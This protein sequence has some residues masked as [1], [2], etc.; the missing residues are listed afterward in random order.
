M[1]NT[2]FKYETFKKDFFS[3]IIVF[4]IAI[5]LCIGIA[6]ACGLSPVSGLI[7]GI[8][9]GIIIGSLSGCPLQV[10]GPAAGLITLVI[11]VVQKYGIEAFGVIVLLAGLIQILVGVFKLA[12]W[13]RA[14]SPAII[15]GMLTGIG[16]MILLSQFHVMLD[17]IPSREPLIN[18]LSIPDAI[19]KGVFPIDGSS[20]HLAAGVGILTISIL[21]LWHYIPQKFKTIPSALVAVLASIIVSTIFNLPIKYISIPSNILD[22]LNILSID[23]LAS[24][25]LNINIIISAITFA[26]IA[27]AETLLSANA[28]DKMAQNSKTNYNKE[29]F[30]QGLGNSIA[31]I[32]GALPITGVIVRSSANIQAGAETRVSTILHGFWIL[33]LVTLCPFILKYIP[34]ACL[35]ALLVYTGYKLVNIQRA[36]EI[37][38]ISK[39]EFIIFLIT[40]LAIL[41]T[42][43]LEGIL[44]G[45]GVSILKNIYRLTL[46]R[47]NIIKNQDEE[48]FVVK[49]TG[50][51]T[52][53]RLPQIA[54]IIENMEPKKNINIIFEHTTVV[55]HSIIDLLIGWSTR[56]T[57][58]GGNVLID[59][60]HLKR[61]YP[62]FG[63]DNCNNIAQ[64]VSKTTSK[65]A[66]RDCAKCKYNYDSSNT[67]NNN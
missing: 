12:P 59:W 44:I 24:N 28:V 6:S 60:N 37:F 9:G 35:A 10:S 48:N 56:Y 26:F 65:Y 47:I 36:K 38:N 52:F 63:W 18:L 40:V 23:I 15:Q 62:S 5:P 21:V 2:K 57:S 32:L 20:H 31:G 61:I 53:L 54:N 14:V 27:S 29:I 55:D 43:L 45:A 39:G 30:A 33:L 25:F 67:K 49:I 34:S 41:S 22:S 42:N 1:I 4:L 58:N 16:L 13:F 19:L 50:N 11:E 66:W 7:S 64:N 17:D 8:I 3:S 46:F 51:L